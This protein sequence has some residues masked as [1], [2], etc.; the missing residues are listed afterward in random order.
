[1]HRDKRRY[2]EGLAVTVFLEKMSSEVR[3]WV[4]K[5]KSLGVSFILC[6]FLC[7]NLL[8]SSCVDPYRPPEISSPDSYLVVNGYFDSAPGAVTSISL[9]RTQNLTDPKLPAVETKAQ[10]TIES[11]NKAVYALRES[12]NG[13]YTLAGVTPTPNETYRLR[14]KTAGGKEYVSDYV[15]V[16]PTPP[17]DSVSWRAQDDGLQINVNAHDPTNRTRYY[18]W[19]F[20]STWEYTTLYNSLLEIKGTQIIDRAEPVFRCWGS[21]NSTNIITTSTARLGQ[22]VVSQFPLVFIPST[23]VKL[24]MKYSI[25]VRQIGLTQTGFEYYDQLARITQNIGSIF[26]PQPT[27]ITGNIRSTTNASDLVLGF[28]RVGSVESKRIF[29]T[30]PQLPGNWITY[31]GLG[32]CQVDTLAKK[33]VLDTKPTIISFDDASGNYYTTTLECADCRARGGV[34]KQPDFWK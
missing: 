33:D 15:P 18:R 20:Q 13:T 16:V 30:R 32:A 22:D 19:D 29:I 6:A 28:F 12:P 26:D 5:R 25:L 14:I 8:L 34:I 2:T 4:Y 27:Q 3:N 11:Q 9:S 23:S 21:D 1:M 24:G 10:V 17:I 31:T 7:P